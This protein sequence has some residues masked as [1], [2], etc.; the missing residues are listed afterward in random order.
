M[1]GKRLLLH[2]V[3]HTCTVVVALFLLC[4]NFNKL[5]ERWL[6][7]LALLYGVCSCPTMF[8]ASKLIILVN[9]RI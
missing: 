8:T 4:Y 5:E 7:F 2:H 3:S 6:L 1:L 9:I